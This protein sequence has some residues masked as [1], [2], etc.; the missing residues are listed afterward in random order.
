MKRMKRS[1][2]CHRRRFNDKKT[3]MIEKK[4]NKIDAL[5][6]RSYTFHKSDIKQ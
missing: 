2:D 5:P 6:M 3:V 1:K 4:S